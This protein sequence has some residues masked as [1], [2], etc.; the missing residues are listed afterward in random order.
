VLHPT[1]TSTSRH[2]RCPLTP[3]LLLPHAASTTSPR[4]SVAIPPTT[5]TPSILPS[6]N[7]QTLDPNPI[8]PPALMYATTGDITGDLQRAR[9]H[10]VAVVCGSRHTR[11]HRLHALS[12]SGASGGGDLSRSR[13]CSRYPP[14]VISSDLRHPSPNNSEFGE[15]ATNVAWNWSMEG[16]RRITR[17][18]YHHRPRLVRSVVAICP[19]RHP[20]PLLLSWPSRSKPQPPSYS[21]KPRFFPLS[22]FCMCAC[23]FLLKRA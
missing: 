21:P 2:P 9:K 23:G 11:R 3:A 19:T 12:L 17:S 8:C 22:R 13:L 5:S 15:W 7:P 20:P 1:P 16:G 6:S 4:P 18:G 14:P 10:P